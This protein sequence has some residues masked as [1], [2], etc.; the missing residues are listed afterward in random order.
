MRPSS[1]VLHDEAKVV[2]LDTFCV[3]SVIE[4]KKT[5]LLSQLVIT[6]EAEGTRSETK[7]TRSWSICELVFELVFGR[8]GDCCRIRLRGGLD[9][10]PQEGEH[11]PLLVLLGE[12]IVVVDAQLLSG[13][14]SL[15]VE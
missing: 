5:H 11:G 8:P 6:E 3:I 15:Q 12:V 2:F 7:S 13:L 9:L 1:S 14:H 10:L 4:E